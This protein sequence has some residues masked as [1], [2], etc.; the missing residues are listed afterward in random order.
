MKNKI[1]YLLYSFI[2]IFIYSCGETEKTNSS[3][4]VKHDTLQTDF[5]FE[6]QSDSILQ[7]G[8]YI[9]HYKNGQVE[10]VGQMKGGKREGV[11]KSYYMDGSPWSETTFIEGVKN[12]KTITWFDNEQK[13]YEGFYK[14]GKESGRWA[15]WSQDG[16][17]ELVKEYK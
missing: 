10:M 6:A 3:N 2:L 11:W 4:L 17:Q 14:D 15:F 7:N 9:T 8:E 5:M 16:K 1:S 13:R 12:G